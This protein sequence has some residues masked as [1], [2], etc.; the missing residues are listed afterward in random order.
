MGEDTALLRIPLMVHL[1]GSNSVHM[2]DDLGPG[3]SMH[4]ATK[5]TQC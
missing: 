5:V 4:G 1:T 2:Q 3:G